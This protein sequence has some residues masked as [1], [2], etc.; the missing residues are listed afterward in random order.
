[1]K[2]LASR[3]GV[4]VYEYA[5]VGNHVHLLVRAK[6]RSA[7]QRFLRSFAGVAARLITGARRGR[8]VGRFWDRLAYSRVVSW[9]REFRCV[10][11]YV[12]RNELEFLGVISYQPR[13]K[14]R[15]ATPAFPGQRLGP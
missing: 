9:G 5:N 14:R 4:R 15:G 3:T 10:R 1:M 2:E 8:S 6:H 7:F 12:I 11:E 13:S